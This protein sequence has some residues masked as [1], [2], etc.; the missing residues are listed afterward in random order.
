MGT[1]L[2]SAADVVGAL[3][4]THWKLFES[5]RCIQDDRSDAAKGLLGRVADAVLNDQHVTALGPVLK[6]EQSKAIDLLTPP[7]TPPEPPTYPPVTPPVKPG[8]EVVDSGARE[9]LSLVEAEN[10]IARLRRKCKETQVM[11]ISVSWV[12]EE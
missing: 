7:S 10:E 11:R 4:A 5:V 8:K 12:I 6:I 9:H 3:A 2:A 1:S